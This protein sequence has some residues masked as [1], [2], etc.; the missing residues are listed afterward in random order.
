M[1]HVMWYKINCIPVSHI[2]HVLQTEIWNYPHWRN[3]G[4]A[5]YY[6][7][8]GESNQN[9]QEAN[10]TSMYLLLDSKNAT[11]YSP[12]W[13]IM[14]EGL[15][16][17]MERVCWRLNRKWIVSLLS[18]PLLYPSPWSD[19]QKQGIWLVPWCCPLTSEKID[20]PT[21]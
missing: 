13:L 8:H 7:K 15:R 20:A 4:N 5:F 3:K 6:R 2:S 14:Y 10:K 12:A 11:P 21:L 9:A 16:L 19:S 1:Y 18:L 17:G